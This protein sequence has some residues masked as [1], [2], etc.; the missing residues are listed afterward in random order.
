MIRVEPMHDQVKRTVAI[1]SHH[2][3]IVIHERESMIVTFHACIRSD[4]LLSSLS[5]RASIHA[6]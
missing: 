1:Q 4:A 6:R 2:H 5:G 3:H